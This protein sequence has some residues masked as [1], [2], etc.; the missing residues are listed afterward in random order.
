MEFSPEK[1]RNSGKIRKI[2]KGGK[3]K[4]KNKKKCGTI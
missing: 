1:S 3:L 4:L 2:R